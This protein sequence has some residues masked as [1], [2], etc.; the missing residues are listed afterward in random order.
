MFKELGFISL[1]IMVLPLQVL[2]GKGSE[3]GFSLGQRLVA[4]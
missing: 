3:L 2:Q 4:S 1:A